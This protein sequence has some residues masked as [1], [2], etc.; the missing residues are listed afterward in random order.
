MNFKDIN[1]YY[2]IEFLTINNKPINDIYKTA[3]LLINNG[4][5]ISTK[6]IDTWLIAFNLKNN[7]LKPIKASDIIKDEELLYY[8][9]L[10][11]V[12]D[13]NKDIIINVFKY[14]H[15]YINNTNYFTKLPLILMYK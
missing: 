12:E 8:K 14:L 11:E 2:I 5:F 13:I 3:I 7:N 9:Q 1:K 6:H 10:F 15:L 4:N